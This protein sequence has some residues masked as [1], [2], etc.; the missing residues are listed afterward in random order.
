MKYGEVTV[1]ESFYHQ[2]YLKLYGNDKYN[3]LGTYV[4][5]GLLPFVEISIRLTKKIDYPKPQALGDRMPS[6]RIKLINEN[7]IIP[8]FLIGAH[9]FFR[10]TDHLTSYNTSTYFAMTK[11]LS[12]SGDDLSLKLDLGY[13]GFKLLKSSGYQFDGLFYG[14]SLKMYK[15]IE[16]IVENDALRFNSGVRVNLFDCISCTAGLM[17]FKNFSGTISY[18]FLL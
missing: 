12:L 13:G 14:A 2:N 9:D 8:S 3:G 17:A 5:L 11:N 6:I 4:S 16:L 7:N 15:N 18:S 1:G 10:T